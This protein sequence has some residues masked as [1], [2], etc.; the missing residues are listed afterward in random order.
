MKFSSVF[1]IDRC[2]KIFYNILMN[3]IRQYNISI[4]YII[5]TI[6]SI[7]RAVFFGRGR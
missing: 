3:K 1:A 7:K 2:E 5:A 4:L 6:L